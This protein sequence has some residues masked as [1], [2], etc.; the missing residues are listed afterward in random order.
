MTAAVE[1]SLTKRFITADLTADDDWSV[2]AND[3][4][5]ENRQIE[6]SWWLAGPTMKTIQTTKLKLGVT[7]RTDAGVEVVGTFSMDVLCKEPAAVSAKDVH[8]ETARASWKKIGTWTDESSDEGLVL[9][10]G[11]DATIAVRLY[12]MTAGGASHAVVSAQQWGPC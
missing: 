9:D 11:G 6:I 12:N 1:T 7:F 2:P 10:V 8:A 4:P 3:E 5:P